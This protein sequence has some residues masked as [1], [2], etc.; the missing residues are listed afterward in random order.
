MGW[1][2]KNTIDVLSSNIDFYPFTCQL[3]EYEIF[4]YGLG[5]SICLDWNKASNGI[6]LFGLEDKVIL[7][8]LC[9]IHVLQYASHEWDNFN[10][11]KK[12]YEYHLR[13]QTSS[14]EWYNLFIKWNQNECNIIELTSELK[15]LY[16]QGHQF[17]DRKLGAWL[18][19]LR[20]TGCSNITP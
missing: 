4:I 17:S 9:K 1:N 5:S 7:Q 15:L 16:L 8:K 13:C 2:N 3:G 10:L 11:M 14:I 6:Q 20:A 19:I 18:S 12:L